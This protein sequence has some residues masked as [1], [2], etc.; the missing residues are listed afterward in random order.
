MG[1]H[2]AFC[3]VI[4]RRGR[5]LLLFQNSPGH[6]AV[7][8]SCYSLTRCLQPRYCDSCSDWAVTQPCVTLAAVQLMAAVQLKLSEP[9]K[10]SLAQAGSLSEPLPCP[11]RHPAAN[12][13]AGPGSG[14]P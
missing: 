10:A 13:P 3:R 6:S 2:P 8:W 5:D 4:G 12:L 1:T 7:Y 14:G 9:A 11:P